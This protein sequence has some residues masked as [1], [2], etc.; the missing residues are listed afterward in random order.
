ME[1]FTNRETGRLDADLMTVR[2]RAGVLEVLLIGN[3]IN[4]TELSPAETVALRDVLTTAIERNGWGVITEHHEP[5]R[6]TKRVTATLTATFHG[7]YLDATE[8]GSHL[9][10]RLDMGFRDR[11][12]LRTWSLDVTNVEEIHGD[13]EGYDS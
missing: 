11:D 8:V 7:D 3:E 13:P 4:E 12:D 6:T 1:L 2:E 10:G 5:E 9:E